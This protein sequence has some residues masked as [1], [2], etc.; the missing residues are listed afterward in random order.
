MTHGLYF[1][2]VR[3][4]ISAKTQRV[5]SFYTRAYQQEERHNHQTFILHKSRNASWWY[6]RRA[7]DKLDLASYIPR[8][9]YTQTSLSDSLLMSALLLLQQGK[10]MAVRKSKLRANGMFCHWMVNLYKRT[11]LTA[12]IIIMTLRQ[13]T[14]NAIFR[15]IIKL[16]MWVRMVTLGVELAVENC[17]EI[18]LD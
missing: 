4:A 10:Q 13:K 2:L 17:L 18:I 5:W 12:A 14:S 1:K 7:R 3:C 16:S 9:S 11:P 8:D 15:Q 6:S